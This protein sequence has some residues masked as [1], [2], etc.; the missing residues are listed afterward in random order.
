[1]ARGKFPQRSCGTSLQLCVYTQTHTPLQAR[2]RTLPRAWVHAFIHTCT[3]MKVSL[4][5]SS[6]PP[7]ALYVFTGKR[8]HA[9][10]LLS[11][12]LSVF[13]PPNSSSFHSLS[14][15]L[16]LSLTASFLCPL[17]FTFS[18]HPPVPSCLP[19]QGCVAVCPG[20]CHK[21]A[22]SRWFVFFTGQL[23][24]PHNV[25]TSS[26]SCFFIGSCL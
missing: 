24:M 9:C 1:M 16:P 12:L 25:G 11:S 23:M 18:F 5:L 10:H 4:S 13:L 14:F 19:S 21:K 2:T 15:C 8:E 26:K 17:R 3:W 20:V 22:S 7:S 6:C